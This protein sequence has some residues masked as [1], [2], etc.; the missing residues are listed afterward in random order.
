MY[1]CVCIMHVHA[2]LYVFGIHVYTSYNCLGKGKREWHWTSRYDFMCVCIQVHVCVY[3]CIHT[4]TYIYTGICLEFKASHAHRNGTMYT[5]MHA[6]TYTHTQAQTLN[7][8][9]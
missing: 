1:V 5:C 3:T 4:R 8:K 9:I 7:V 6:H 2:C